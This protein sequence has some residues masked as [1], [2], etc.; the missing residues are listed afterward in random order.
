MNVLRSTQ[1]NLVAEK[2]LVIV[3]ELLDPLILEVLFREEAA[4]HA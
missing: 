3:L 4:L 2:L 1:T